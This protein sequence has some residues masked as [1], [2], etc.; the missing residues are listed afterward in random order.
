MTIKK[1]KEDLY[2]HKG[3]NAIIRCDL[4][5]NKIEEYN[6]VINDLYNHVFTVKLKNDELKSFSY[7][8]I[9]TKTIKINY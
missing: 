2:N 7:S 1:I 4:G 6:V 9:I 5:R 8:D 3:S